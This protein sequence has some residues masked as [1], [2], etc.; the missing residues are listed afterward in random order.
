[1]DPLEPLIENLRAEGRPRVWSLVITAFGDLVQHRGG[2]V[3]N[4]RLNALLGRIGIE[5]GALRTAL[6]R[7]D[8]DGWVDRERN[9]RSSL[10]RLSRVGL[11][12]FDPATSVIYAPPRKTPVAVWRLSVALDKGVPTV[13]LTPADVPPLNSDLQVSGQVERVSDAYKSAFLEP[14]YRRALTVLDEDIAA[15]PKALDPLDAAAARLLLIHRWRRIVLRFPE[16][17]PALLPKDCP[18]P[19]PRA[20]VAR[21]YEMLSGPAEEWLSLPQNGAPSMPQADPNFA[22][23]FGLSTQA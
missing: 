22:I 15:I 11:T 7:L 16:P 1:M 17:E 23:R 18:L 6:S 5:P 3:S 9:G 13:R 10:C 21:A 14:A 2:A 8:R 4:K 20:A 12:Q 19:D